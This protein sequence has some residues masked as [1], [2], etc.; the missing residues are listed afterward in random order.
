MDVNDN[1]LKF[2][3]D[4]YV[5]MFLENVVVGMIVEVV[6]VNDVDV[7]RNGL[8]SYKIGIGSEFGNVLRM[9]NSYV[10]NY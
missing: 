5:W 6:W 3:C 4:L 8:V 1:L 9:K 2:I 10:V 7:G